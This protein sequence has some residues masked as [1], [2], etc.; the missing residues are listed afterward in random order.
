MIIA[1]WKIFT[2][3]GQPH[4]VAEWPEPPPWRAFD[5]PEKVKQDRPLPKDDKEAE[6]MAEEM[7]GERGRN[8][9]ISYDQNLQS[10]PDRIKYNH[11]IEM[12]NAALYLRRPLLITGDPGSG[13]SSLIYPVAYELALGSV[14][15]WSITSRSN[16]KEGL[17]E[18][19]PIGRLQD[20]QLH[21]DREPDIENYLRL[22]PLGTAL[23]PTKRPRAL[24]IDEIDKADIDLPSD[25]LNIFEEGEFRI[26]E[27]E[28]LKEPESE[29]PKGLESKYPKKDKPG[30]PKMIRAYGNE[31]SF[32][33]T[34]G[35]IRCCEF[36]FVVLT[37]NREREF[38]APFLR[39]CLQLEMPKPNETLLETIV[40]VHL[41]DLGEE[42][43]TEVH[44]IIADFLKR[45]DSQILA[46]DQLLNAIFLVT[47]DKPFGPEEKKRLIEALLKALTTVGS[48]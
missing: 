38:P 7:V 16:L 44:D 31:G 8:F 33:V 20:A 10:D 19:D 24:L 23:L 30:K 45:R 12:I 37:S 15:R 21:K 6:K 35:H 5:K 9:R 2:G 25:L 17:Y 27:L 1:D 11:V 48:P 22:G 18:Y 28:R 40:K 43:I 13:K 29:P 46:T 41:K 42:V 32:P 39:R 4:Y 36:P 3:S 14:L 34:D 47:R 26:P